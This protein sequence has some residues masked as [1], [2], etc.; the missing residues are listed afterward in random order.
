MTH[1]HQKIESL[2]LTLTNRLYVCFCALDDSISL[3]SP[4]I[5]TKHNFQ[6]CENFVNLPE[7]EI[8]VQSTEYDFNL[9]SSSDED[10]DV[11][12]PGSNLTVDDF[13]TM[14]N[15]LNYDHHLSDLRCFGYISISSA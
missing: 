12:Y 2:F 4:S 5:S 11:L 8:L 9:C 14:L 7:H 6:E 10:E 1:T 15:K 13:K 3:H